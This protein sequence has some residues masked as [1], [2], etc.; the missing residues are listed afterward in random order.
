M[1]DVIIA[2]MYF[3]C[4]MLFDI[5]KGECGNK[6]FNYSYNVR[7]KENRNKNNV[8]DFHSHHETS[9]PTNNS[10][11]YKSEKEHQNIL[12]NSTFYRSIYKED[13]HSY[14][15]DS[16]KREEVRMVNPLSKVDAMSGKMVW[17]SGENDG[18]CNQKEG[19]GLILCCCCR[20]SEDE[21][22]VPE[23]SAEHDR[24]YSMSDPKVYC[25]IAA[26]SI[27][28]ASN[29]ATVVATQYV[30]NYTRI[31]QQEEKKK[32]KLQNLL[33]RTHVNKYGYDKQLKYESY[34]ADES[35]LT[36]D[37]ENQRHAKKSRNI[38]RRLK[39]RE[40]EK[41]SF[42]KPPLAE[43][44]NRQR[45]GAEPSDASNLTALSI[46]TVEII[47]TEYPEVANVPR[48]SYEVSFVSLPFLFLNIRATYAV[49]Y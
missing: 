34:H 8:I 3:R 9:V 20:R 36:D 13:D 14:L 45:L 17:V 23:P 10:V 29:T 16:M 1:S 19:T 39:K 38:L 49:I 43:Y 33:Q 5:T 47:E 7:N 12:G 28:T 21:R 40:T 4:G 42:L 30:E 18:L 27:V 2:Q 35:D 22:I 41:S 44:G 25:D 24:Q 32:S 15:V 26:Q 46:D 6:K 31:E 48:L 11:I 37:T